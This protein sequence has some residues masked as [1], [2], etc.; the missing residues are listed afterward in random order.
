MEKNIEMFKTWAPPH[1]TWSQWAKPA[2]FANMPTPQ[3]DAPQTTLNI[4]TETIL[5]A[6]DPGTAI[7]IDL[8]GASSVEEGIALAQLG[9]RPIPLYNGVEQTGTL[10][11]V[12][13]TAQL[14]E[15]IVTATDIL[16]NIP[17]APNAPPAFLLD[18]N[19]GGA[20]GQTTDTTQQY[21]N[22]WNVFSNDFPR[23]NQLRGAGIDQVIIFSDRQ[24]EDMVDVAGEFAAQ[25]LAVYFTDGDT[26][27][28]M[29]MEKAKWYHRILDFIEGL[30]RPFII[31]HRPL[32]YRR[33]RNSFYKYNEGNRY[34]G[35]FPTTVRTGGY[36]NGGQPRSTF[37]GGRSYSGSGYG[38]YGKGYGGSGG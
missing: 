23:A 34:P 31:H 18:A 36:Y 21:D 37:G 17:I 29:H 5:T 11:P 6:L 7:I 14:S 3:L 26:N 9:Y 20:P 25:G 13:A 19:R 16:A 12:V 33:M 15:A 1:V 24:M 30:H 2:V 27:H 35:N 8:P 32:G 38:G 28:I 10:S 4:P 22:R